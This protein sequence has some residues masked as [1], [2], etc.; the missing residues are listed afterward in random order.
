MNHNEIMKSYI[1]STL[2][3]HGVG[4]RKALRMIKHAIFVNKKDDMAIFDGSPSVFCIWANQGKYANSW[5]EVGRR[6]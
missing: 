5:V 3:E 4:K 1:Y 6:A 2:R